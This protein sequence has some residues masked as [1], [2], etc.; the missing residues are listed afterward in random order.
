MQL[1]PLLTH[2][3]QRNKK[4][5][6]N[7]KRNKLLEQIQKLQGDHKGRTMPT[8]LTTKQESPM[9]INVLTQE[10]EHGA[11]G[12]ASHLLIRVL[13]P[14]PGQKIASIDLTTLPDFLGIVE[15]SFDIAGLKTAS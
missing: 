10:F 14:S 5:R 4:L 6:R 11:N 2:G 9:V 1:R 7:Q 8:R 12:V 13:K 15:G 3:Q